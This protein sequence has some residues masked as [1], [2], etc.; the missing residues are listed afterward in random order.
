[1]IVRAIG[2]VIYGLDSFRVEVEVDV[3]R[4]LPQ[5]STVG[6][7]DTSVKE[8]KDRIRAAIKNAGYPFP[9]EHVTVNLAPA[10]IRKEGTGLDLP[11]AIA[12]LASESIVPPETL[13]KYVLM[14]ELSLDGSIKGVPGVI[15]AAFHARS[16]GYE[17]L[18]VAAD[19]AFEA[20]VVE[21]I[22]VIPVRTLGEAVEFLSGRL[23]IE[24]VRVDTD[25]LLLKGENCPL[26]FAEIRGQELAKRA[27]EIAAAGGHN[28]IMIGPPGSGKTMLAQR[29]PTIMPDLTLEEAVETTKIYSVA[30]LMEKGQGLISRRPFRAPHHTISDAGLIGGGQIPKPGEISLAHNGVLFLDELPEFKKNV[31]ESIRQPLE[32]GWVTISR[33]AV[34]V[35]Y[36][37]RFM[38]VAAMNPCPCGHFG[39][40]KRA[41]RCTGQQIRQ[42]Q[43]K[44]SGPLLDR[45]D[46]HIEVPAVG[47]TELVNRS[48]VESSRE[49]KERVMRAREIQKKRLLGKVVPVNASLN[50]KEIKAL[51]T[52]DAEGEKLLRDAM[53]RLGLSARAYVRI[54]KVARTIADLAGEEQIAPPH[55]AEAIQYRSMDRRFV[56]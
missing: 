31:L 49:I 4:G 54:L 17:A 38:L 20:A 12:I 46:I 56:I 42:Y 35:T 44:I 52:L 16:W 11:I 47:Y 43:G 18:M 26:D 32:N 14:G 29:L 48:W 51:C 3:S 33:S 34:T 8:S 45:I 40:G 23:A 55:I 13:T 7:P 22:D 19:A 27:I 15:S 41:C 10:D 25:A 50:D 37:A 6:L 24:P 2:C 1:M 30:G 9:R 5:F 39:D 28:V 21:G 36:P 53:E